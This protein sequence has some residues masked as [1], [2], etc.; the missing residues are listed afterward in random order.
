MIF[1]KGADERPNE[2]A[3]NKKLK[4]GSLFR[5]FWRLNFHWYWK[6]K[7]KL[8]TIVSQSFIYAA[9]G[10]VDRLFHAHYQRAWR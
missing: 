3:F 7:N 1:E 2:M 8:K 9:R 4:P 6:D 10:S 5:L